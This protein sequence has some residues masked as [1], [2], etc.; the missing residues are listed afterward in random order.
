MRLWDSF[1]VKWRAID[2]KRFYNPPQNSIL[3][4][5]GAKV[6]VSFC[7]AAFLSAR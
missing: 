2:P 6:E 5:A 4:Y 7:Q 3:G 1:R